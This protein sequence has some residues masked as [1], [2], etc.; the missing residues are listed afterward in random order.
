MK[1]IILFVIV[2]LHGCN[3]ERVEKLGQSLETTE[4][5][6]NILA[7]PNI[8]WKVGWN[9]RYKGIIKRHNQKSGL[10]FAFTKNLS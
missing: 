9:L 2:F 6:L 5:V 4:N 7:L 10:N 8:K 3:P 1:L